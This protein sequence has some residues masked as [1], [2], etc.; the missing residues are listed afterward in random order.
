MFKHVSPANPLLKDVWQ[1]SRIAYGTYGLALGLMQFVFYVFLYDKL[2]AD[3]L[4][5][6]KSVF[7]FLLTSLACFFLEVPIGAL[8][9]YIGR[10]KTVVLSFFTAAVAYFFRSWIYFAPSPN[11]AFVLAITSVLFHS[12]S[13]TLFSGSFVAWI[14]DTVKGR[15]VKEGYGPLLARGSS[16][17]LLMKI[18]GAM[19]GMSLFL[20][21]YVFYVFALSSIIALLCAIYCGIMMKETEALKFHGGA[22]FIRYTI[23]RMVNIMRIGFKATFTTPPLL[24]LLSVSA[25]FT[26]LM[27]LVNCLWP[28]AMKAN[29]GIEKMT[30]H[31]FFLVFTG[32]VGAFLGAKFLEFLQHENIRKN[33]DSLPPSSL[34]LWI[35]GASLLMGIP[36]LI[37]GFLHWDGMMT[38]GIFTAGFVCFNIGFGFLMP[39]ITTLKNH[40]IPAEHSTER[41]TILSWQSMITE[42]FIVALAFPSSGPSGEKTVVGW[43]LPASLLIISALVVNVLLRRYQRK[44]GELPAKKRSLAGETVT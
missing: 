25:S 29:F 30:F 19:I 9:D 42:I 34:W 41:A 36:I 6:K 18:V 22:L 21:G 39:S 35:L 16:V 3:A 44:V 38:I 1:V 37:L 33:Q 32:L 27:L 11:F 31:W 12:I 40:Y 13:Y 2:G 23:D 5:L 10:K 43:I 28:I 8:G 24:Y 7:I 26:V 15:N 14:V 17:M 20:S 4:A